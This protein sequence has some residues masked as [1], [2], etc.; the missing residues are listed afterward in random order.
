MKTLKIDWLDECPKCG[1]A[2]VI[3][4]DGECAWVVWDEID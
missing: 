3:E 1:H 2:G 4:T